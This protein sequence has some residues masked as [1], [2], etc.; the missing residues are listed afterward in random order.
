MAK[1]EIAE[2]KNYALY[3]QYGDNSMGS[4]GPL[5]LIP[6]VNSTELTAEVNDRLFRRRTEYQSEL[7]RS[8]GTGFLRKD[9]TIGADYTRYS[10]GEG[11]VIIQGSV[12]GHDV[13]I[14]CDVLNHSC[15]YPLF[16]EEKFMSPDEHYQDLKRVILA[17]S[18]K[19][20]RINVIMPFLYD[21][22]QHKRNGRESLDCAFMLEELHNLGVNSIITFDAHDPRVANAIPV[23]GF[24]NIPATYQIIKSLA[25]EMGTLSTK[26]PNLM[27]IS[28]DEGALPR[29]MY[30]ANVLGCPLGTF[31]KRRDYTKVVDGRNPILKHEFLGESAKGKDVLIIDDM[32]ASGD[33]MLD[34]CKEMRALGARNI[35]CAATFGLFTSGTAIFDQAYAEGYLTRVFTTNLIYRLPELKNAAWFREV[36]S[37]KFLALLIDAIN[38]DAS[39]TQ[40]VNQT[41]RIRAYLGR[42][43]KKNAPVRSSQVSKSRSKS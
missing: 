43:R 10:T 42:K 36:N 7:A 26:N 9:Y 24:E 5:G 31:Y 14:L 4:I 13:F 1:L 40:M 19:A 12:R 38:H 2:D 27:I 21:S 39:L 37:S 16:G 30:Y 25:Q 11:R 8:Q 35:Y 17:I 29:S 18:G 32:I 22:R 28:P 3:E 6:M 33:S 20:R 34:I 23:S 15:T 41:D